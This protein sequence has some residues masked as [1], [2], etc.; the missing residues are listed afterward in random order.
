MSNHF[1][2]HREVLFT[3]R[4]AM[5]NGIQDLLIQPVHFFGSYICNYV[6]S[7][8]S[9]RWPVSSNMS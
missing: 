6:D 5:N 8:V 9:T 3:S 1:H 7:R 4:D 2:V